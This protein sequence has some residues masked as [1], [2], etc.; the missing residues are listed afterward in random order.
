MALGP[1]RDVQLGF[2]HLVAACGGPRNAARTLRVS[3]STVYRWLAD[4]PPW[5]AAALLWWSSSYG[6]HDLELEAGRRLQLLA[7]K[8]HI[9]EKKARDAESRANQLEAVVRALTA[10]NDGASSI[11]AS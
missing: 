6:R 9:V 1:P 2:D 7:W 3:R 8:L 11:A 5:W 4:C 10:A